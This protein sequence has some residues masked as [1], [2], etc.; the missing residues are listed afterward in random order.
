MFK[1]C[2]NGFKSLMLCEISSSGI[3]VLYLSLVRELFIISLKPLFDKRFDIDA[4][5]FSELLLSF[6]VIIVLSLEG[7][8]T[9]L[10]P[11]ILN[12]S[13]ITSTSLLT[14][15]LYGGINNV[16]PS[17]FESAISISRSLRIEITLFL[18]I[19]SPINLSILS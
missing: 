10:N 11:Y 3:N 8:V 19:Y 12:I 14:S 2:D 16:N 7:I 4:L 1:S 13:S 15:A 5:I 18:S 17:S 6:D 9:L